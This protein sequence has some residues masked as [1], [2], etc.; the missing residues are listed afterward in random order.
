[1]TDSSLEAYLD[2][3]EAEFEESIASGRSMVDT[4]DGLSDEEA[5]HLIADA[6]PELRKNLKRSLR[7][8]EDGLARLRGLRGGARKADEDEAR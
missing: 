2:N 3:L 1:M 5:V 6:L 8:Q 4:M 7:T